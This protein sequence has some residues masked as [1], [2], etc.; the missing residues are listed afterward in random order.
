MF[1]MSECVADDSKVEDCDKGRPRKTLKQLRKETGEEH[2]ARALLEAMQQ[3]V[4][5]AYARASETEQRLCRELVEHVCSWDR[6]CGRPQNISDKM[7]QMMQSINTKSENLDKDFAETLVETQQSG[8]NE[9]AKT[10]RAWVEK[11]DDESH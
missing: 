7:R 6:E 4:N 11:E 5:E 1:K 2:E 8:W 3:N 10:T 9:T